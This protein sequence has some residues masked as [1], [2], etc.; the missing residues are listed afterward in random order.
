MAGACWRGIFC[1]LRGR[2]GG[3]V[4]VFITI[5]TDVLTAIV[6]AKVPPDMDEPLNLEWEAMK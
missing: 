2:T 4:L 6:V 5:T 1:L 3:E